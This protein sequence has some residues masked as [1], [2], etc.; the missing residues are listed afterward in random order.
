MF[1]NFYVWLGVKQ[2]DFITV[3]VVTTCRYVFY[4][5]FKNWNVFSA[6]FTVFLPEVGRTEQTVWF[7][8]LAPPNRDTRI[9]A[10]MLT[11]KISPEIRAMLSRF[12]LVP[13][14]TFTIERLFLLLIKREHQFSLSIDTGRTF[15]S[16]RNN[17]QWIGWVIQVAVKWT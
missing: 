6:N 2:L 17:A 11:T 10:S 5:I 12:C 9:G 4:A 14:F 1:G 13:T 16:R 7:A 8:I 3:C 15:L